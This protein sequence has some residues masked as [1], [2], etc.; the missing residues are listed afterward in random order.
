MQ[1]FAGHGVIERRLR[2]NN[3]YS[4]LIKQPWCSEADHAYGT[5]HKFHVVMMEPYGQ[6]IRTDL[7]QT[8]AIPVRQ[9]PELL[10]GDRVNRSR[11][12][13]VLGVREPRAMEDVSVMKYKHSSTHE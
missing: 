7:N 11:K 10:H 5:H 1:A 2:A 9:M 3:R 12:T 4:C 13:R 8:D 6:V